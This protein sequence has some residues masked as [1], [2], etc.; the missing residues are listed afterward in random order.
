MLATPY[1]MKVCSFPS[2][3]GSS[4][5][6]QTF[7]FLVSSVLTLNFFFFFSFFFSN[8]WTRWRP[9]SDE[10]QV[11]HPRRV[12]CKCISVCLKWA[13]VNQC[14]ATNTL[15]LLIHNLVFYTRTCNPSWACYVAL[16]LMNLFWWSDLLVGTS[17]PQM[18]NA[19]FSRY[20]CCYESCRWLR[21]TFCRVKN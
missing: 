12:S 13:E 4:M 5:S 11:L 18:R 17:C 8:S 3:P 20:Y 9:E 1:Q 14:P 15:V 2:A 7:E 16:N 10:S 21:N 6:R 19:D